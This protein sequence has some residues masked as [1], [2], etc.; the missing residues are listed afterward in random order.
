M[1]KFRGTGVLRRMF[2]RLPSLCVFLVALL[3][4]AGCATSAPDATG[5]AVVEST[6][7]DGAYVDVWQAT[8]K[9]LRDEELIVFTRDKRGLF[10]A[11]DDLGRHRLVPRRR[12]FS[13]VVEEVSATSSKVTVETLDQE[14]GV[15]LLRYPDWH[16]RKTTESERGKDILEAVTQAVVNPVA[17]AKTPE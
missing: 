8:K 5:F 6:V 2:V 10:V 1:L 11:Y 17:E 14:Y 15:R 4:V 13:V 9:V 16:D 12:Q 7:L 3:F